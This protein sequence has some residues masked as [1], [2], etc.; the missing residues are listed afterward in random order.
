MNINVFILYSNIDNYKNNNNYNIKIYKKIGEG[1]YGIVHKLDSKHVIKIFKHSY[2]NKINENS[3]KIIPL[4]QE[5]REI[6]FFID[7]LKYKKE[8]E[9]YF[10]DV[11]LVGYINCNFFY[12]KIINLKDSYFIIMPY[13]LPIHKLINRY[14]F[15]LINEEYRYNFAIQI[16]LRLVQIQQYI[17]YKY[18]YINYDVKLKNFM[19]NNNDLSI[20]NIVNIDFSLIIRNN[21]DKYNFNYDYNIWPKIDN[22]ELNYIIPYSICVNALVILFGKKFIV[23]LNKDNYLE[24]IKLLKTRPL[25]YDIFSKGM[26]LKISN[27]RF[28][29]L[30]KNYFRKIKN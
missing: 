3:K 11:K 18:D 8:N 2:F 20:K 4:K 16:M 28:N 25:I 6:N 14:K 29:H 24:K 27:D 13:C 22:I 17:I 21:K 9:N 10:I 12:N 30:L 5:N 7:Y 15:N 26:S 19:I 23:N 1:G